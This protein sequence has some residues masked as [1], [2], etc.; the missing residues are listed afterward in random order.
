VKQ[1]NRA[2]QPHRGGAAVP[3]LV[4]L[5][6]IIAVCLIAIGTWVGV[7][8]GKDTSNNNNIDNESVENDGSSPSMFVPDLEFAKAIFAPQRAS[9]WTSSQ[10]STRPFG[11]LSTR[12]QP[13]RY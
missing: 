4:I 8:N 7:K 2:A 10:Y 12:I 9:S 3:K 1:T 5:T 13:T 6:I 11:G